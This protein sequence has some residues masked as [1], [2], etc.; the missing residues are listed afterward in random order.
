MLHWDCEGMGMWGCG[1]EGV[2]EW[3][4][5]LLW[6]ER[7]RFFHCTV[8]LTTFSALEMTPSSM[9][10][11]SVCHVSLRFSSF[12]QISVKVIAAPCIFPSWRS[13]KKKPKWIFI[14]EILVFCLFCYCLFL[15]STKSWCQ[16]RVCVRST[17]SFFFAVSSHIFVVCFFSG[18]SYGYKNYVPEGS[19]VSFL[20]LSSEN[21]LPKNLVLLWWS[22]MLF[23]WLCKISASSLALISS[24]CAFCSS[25]DK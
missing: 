23:S 3:G 21:S 14:N 2:R 18:I 5:W 9:R 11:E 6:G 10:V 7:R 12:R 16:S 17:L 4:G 25:S 8:S 13:K 15:A 22:F 24:S 1:G 19:C 20:P